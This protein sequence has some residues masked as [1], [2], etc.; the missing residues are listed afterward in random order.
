[1]T[2]A[3]R[4]LVAE[5][6]TSLHTSIKLPHVANGCTALLVTTADAQGNIKLEHTVPVIVLTPLEAA[7]LIQEP[8]VADLAQIQ[9][10]LPEN[11]RAWRAACDNLK[12]FKH[13]QVCATA[14]ELTIGTVKGPFSSEYLTK[15]SKLKS[16][17]TLMASQSPATNANSSEAALES[18]SSQASS[19]LESSSVTLEVKDLCKAMQAIQAN[20]THGIVSVV[21][22]HSLLLYFFLVKTKTE[23][24]KSMLITK[25]LSS[26]DFQA[27]FIVGIHSGD[28]S[29]TSS[30]ACWSS[31]SILASSEGFH[32]GIGFRMGV[33]EVLIARQNGGNFEK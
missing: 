27:W 23:Q 17:S 30:T 1:M 15:W 22:E 26:I 3:F 25:K 9:L 10:L 19:V 33:V 29:S 31:G 4:G 16:V 11:F 21:H 5:F 18:F 24:I 13:L 14:N 12:H 28:S 8:D 6:C 32:F 20:P 7:S 2:K